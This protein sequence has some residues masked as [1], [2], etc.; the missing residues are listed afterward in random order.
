MKLGVS[1]DIS[2]L[3]KESSTN[4]KISTFTDAHRPFEQNILIITVGLP[5]YEK[6]FFSCKIMRYL[7]WL[8]FPS[9]LFSKNSYFNPDTTYSN[10][11]YDIHQTVVDI[12]DWFN[13][14]GTIAVLDGIHYSKAERELIVEKM[15]ESSDIITPIFI[16]FKANENGIFIFIKYSQLIL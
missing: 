2:P 3:K 10:I 11:S 13:S 5:V 6:S 14:N 4:K 1:T 8:G 7:D 9:K 16:E 12:L 15:E